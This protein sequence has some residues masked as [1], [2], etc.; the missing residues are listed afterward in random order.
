METTDITR[1]IKIDEVSLRLENLFYQLNNRPN[2]NQV[3]RGK[4]S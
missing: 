3:R 4:I 2:G 1:L